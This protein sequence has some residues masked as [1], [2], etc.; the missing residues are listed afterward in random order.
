LYILS[1]VTVGTTG[2]VEV[3]ALMSEF[4]PGEHGRNVEMCSVVGQRIG[5]AR[6]A[7]HFIMCAWTVVNTEQPS[8]LECRRIRDESS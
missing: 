5:V 2:L 3:G 6:E 1:S 7:M 4:I 8:R